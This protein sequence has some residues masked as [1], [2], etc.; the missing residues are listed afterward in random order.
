MADPYISWP[1]TDGDTVYG[2]DVAFDW[3][4]NDNEDVTGWQLY[5][6]SSTGASDYYD[7]GIIEN[8]VRGA[9]A[10]GLPEGSATVYVRLRWFNGTWSTADTSY[11]NADNEDRVSYETSLYYIEECPRWYKCDRCNFLFPEWDTAIDP[12]SGLRVCLV[13]PRCYDDHEFGIREVVI[14][15]R[16]DPVYRERSSG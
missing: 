15:G 2:S 16:T 7:S 12:K 1:E 8:P 10:Q 13:G 4:D 6:G 11:T 14:T 3:D 9:M 5:V